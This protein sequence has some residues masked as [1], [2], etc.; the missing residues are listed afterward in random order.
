MLRQYL[1]ICVPVAGLLL[2]FSCHRSDTQ[3][4]LIGSWYWIRSNGGFSYQVLTPQ[5]TGIERIFKFY[6]N[7]TVKIYENGELVQN[8]DYF[9]SREESILY[10]DTFDF[11]TINYRYYVGDSLIILPMR[12]IIR[13]LSDSLII[14]E[15]VFDGFKHTYVRVRD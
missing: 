14:E 7:D 11:V 2:F 13:E 8:T 12:Y 3:P 5:S 4:D 10:H 9:L 15:D 1:R 6:K